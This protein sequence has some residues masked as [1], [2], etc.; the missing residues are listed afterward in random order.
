[1]STPKTSTQLYRDCLRLVRHM[2]GASSP[3]AAHLSRIVG[4][5]FRANAGVVAPEA[6]H[7]LKQAAERS[8]SSYLLFQR[9]KM[10]PKIAAAAVHADAFEDDEHGN[11]VR[12]AAPAPAPAAA[13]A[14]AA[15]AVAAKR[16]AAARLRAE[17]AEAER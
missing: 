8:L 16:K 14:A 3:K 12:V 2:A 13:A 5:Q 6:V 11:L 15:A 7:A 17:A 1:M 10:D 4:A 9:A